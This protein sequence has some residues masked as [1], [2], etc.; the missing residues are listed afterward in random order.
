MAGNAED[1]TEHG[2]SAQNPPEHRGAGDRAGVSG[3]P[4]THD[5]GGDIGRTPPSTRGGGGLGPQEVREADAHARGDDRSPDV[6]DDDGGGAE[7]GGTYHGE[8]VGRQERVSSGPATG[9]P[10][11]PHPA[12][13]HHSDEPRE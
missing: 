11:H 10:G 2:A 9:T 12:E 6:V 1:A 4:G 13:V 7:Q 8:G 5:M 3:E